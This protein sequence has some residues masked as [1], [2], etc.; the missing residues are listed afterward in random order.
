MDSVNPQAPP[1]PL[2]AGLGIKVY[3]YR[4]LI[5]RHWW[6]LA[7]TIGLGLAYEAYV[8]FSKPPLFESTSPLI[9]REEMS[10]GANDKVSFNDPRDNIFGTAVSLLKSNMVVD[11]ARSRL[12]LEAPTLTGKV[13][14]SSSAEVHTNIFIVT[15]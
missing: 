9:M 11:R 13:D 15:G 10:S 3:R 7:L 12:A 6:V 2:A 4:S 14:V 8:L 1:V 5:R